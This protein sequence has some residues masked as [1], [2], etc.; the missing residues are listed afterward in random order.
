MYPDK[1]VH[2]KG[3]YFYKQPIPEYTLF[4][5]EGCFFKTRSDVQASQLEKGIAPDDS[6][7]G[8]E[9]ASSAGQLHVGSRD[10]T[11]LSEVISPRGNYA[12]FYDG[13]YQSIAH[14]RPEPVTTDAAVRVMQII[15]AA[16]ASHAG[17]KVIELGAQ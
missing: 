5:K 13:L 12:E 4:G 17:R 14:D 3:G 7:Y 9:P 1:R 10:K 11:E 16:L 2:V 8:L 15:D 6:A